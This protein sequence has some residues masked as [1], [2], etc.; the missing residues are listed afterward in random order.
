MVQECRESP[1]CSASIGERRNLAVVAC[2]VVRDTVAIIGTW[3]ATR[4]A[5]SPPFPNRVGKRLNWNCEGQ[6]T[7]PHVYQ[8]RATTD[9]ATALS[10]ATERPSAQ[11][12]G[13]LTAGTPRTHKAQWARSHSN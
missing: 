9:K 6:A 4:P 2:T 12:P 8:A 11:Q 10:G 7:T 3:Q 5:S 1:K 13:H